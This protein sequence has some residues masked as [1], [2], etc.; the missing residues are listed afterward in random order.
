MAERVVALPF[1]LEIDWKL[2]GNGL[3]IFVKSSRKLPSNTLQ[4]IRSK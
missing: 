3:A 4:V 1:L 2:I